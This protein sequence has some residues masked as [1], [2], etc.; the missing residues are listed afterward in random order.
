[1]ATYFPEIP[2]AH[3]VDTFTDN[4]ACAEHLL[5][6]DLM[7]DQ[8]VVVMFLEALPEYCV[9]DAKDLG[10]ST[11]NS[12]RS[13]IKDL[14][15]QAGYLWKDDSKFQR[16]LSEWCKGNQRTIAEYRLQGAS[17]ARIGKR[18]MFFD[19]YVALAKAYFNAG[20]LFEWAYHVLT[21]NL[22]T[23]GNST[24]ALRWRHIDLANDSHIFIV[25]KSKSDQ[26]GVKLDPKHVFA[27]SRN[28]YIC[29][30][31]A[32][33]LYTLCLRQQDPVEIFPGGNQ[34]SRFSKALRREKKDNKD[35]LEMLRAR[36]YDVSDIGVHSI[37]KG[38]GS[39]AANGIVGMSPSIS[40]ICL[41]AGWTQGAIKDKYLKYEHAADT[42]LGRVLAGMPTTSKDIVHFADLP[43][44]WG[45]N[46]ADKDV[47]AALKVAFPCTQ[48]PRFPASSLGV[49]NRMLAVI[50]KNHFWLENVALTSI[51][52]RN[53]PYFSTEFY[54]R[55][56]A[57]T[58]YDKLDED[59]TLCTPSGVPA[60]VFG[61]MEC[62]AI[63]KL[64]IKLIEITLPQQ[65]EEV[66]L[67]VERI[68]EEK[69]V[70]EGNVTHRQVMQML[71]DRIARIEKAMLGPSGVFTAPSG[72]ART[73]A[74]GDDGTSDRIVRRMGLT[75]WNEWRHVVMVDGV[76]K[77][78]WFAIPP[79]CRYPNTR[80]G[81]LP[82]L[83]QYY[84]GRVVEGTKGDHIIMPVANMTAQNVPAN[85]KKDPATGQVTT[86]H[87]S[88]L[89]ECRQFVMF[90][91]GN[92]RE[93]WP[94][95]ERG[96]SIPPPRR[97]VGQMHEHACIILGQC[98]PT[99]EVPAA[100]RRKTSNQKG[101]TTHLKELR[102]W[103]R[104]CGITGALSNMIVEVDA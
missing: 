17:K 57:S 56:L 86:R 93:N 67:G 89:S 85:T 77:N 27:N 90:L 20:M 39:F 82:L 78:K 55:G 26:E 38:A 32:L 83:L 100:K 68:L 42:Y 101:W 10:E 54:L 75:P 91:E 94:D 98:L 79:K 13:A 3:K 99:S 50:V 41:R 6:M 62:R 11:F 1:M 63:K 51:E 43:P 104:E 81:V 16:E 5:N 46:I 25:P 53:H 69:G 72:D 97:D 18:H 58:I 36:G 28:P 8:N 80:T 31:F 52:D 45:K 88:R 48:D 37:R 103:K 44:T 71:D 66:L 2:L 73:E 92:I 34:L 87:R 15:K 102:K 40:A 21:W 60:F 19:L 65:R 9:K 49:F 29:P 30:I 47:Q 7:D 59:P 23:R 84:H 70:R 24:A 33:G 64:I 4:P 76:P 22:M 96:Y 35:I 61:I 12:A 95:E 14:F 74:R